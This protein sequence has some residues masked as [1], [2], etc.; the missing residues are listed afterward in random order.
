MRT[1]LCK[2]CGLEFQTTEELLLHLRGHEGRPALLN[3]RGSTHGDFANNAA[4]SQANCKVLVNGHNPHWQ[5]AIFNFIVK[6][7]VHFIS[8][9]FSVF[10]NFMTS[11]TLT[12][13]LM[14]LLP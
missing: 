3:E 5:R 12:A 14:I 10:F 8:I 6:Q 4:I 13:F 9:N 1:Q 2:I 7:V 11:A